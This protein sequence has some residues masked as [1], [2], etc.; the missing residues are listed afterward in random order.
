MCN[1]EV[2]TFLGLGPPCLLINIIPKQ[3]VRLIIKQKI[4][5]MYIT[6]FISMTTLCGTESIM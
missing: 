1:F 5:G 2:L 6:F 3:R 4:L